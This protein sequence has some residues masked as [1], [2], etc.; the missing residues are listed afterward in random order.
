MAG[1]I[2]PIQLGLTDGDLVTLWAP[3]WREGDDEW[4]AFLGHGDD[5]YGFSSAAELA[6]FV[7]SDREHDLVEHPS[8]AIVA[9]LSAAEFEPDDTHVFDLVGV[10]E[11]VAG[12]PDADALGELE[13]TFEI[14]RSIGEVCDLDVVIRYFGANPVLD[15]V[16]AGEPAFVGRDGEQRWDQIGTAVASGWEAVIDAID[17]VV[18]T[19]QVDAAAVAEAEAEIVAAQENVVDADDAAEEGDDEDDDI[20]YV[21]LDGETDEEEGDDEETFWTSV[22]IDPVKIIT[23]ADTYFTLRCYL[24]D[25]P[26]FLGRAGKILAFTSE[27]AL[28]RFLADDHDHALARVSTYAEVQAAA[29]DGSLDVE[30]TDENV[31]VLPGLADDLADGPQSVDADQLDLA[32]E[33]FTDAAQFAGDESTEQALAPSTPLGWYVS[34]TLNPDPTRL[35]PSA[36]FTAEAQSWRD[37]EREFEARLQLV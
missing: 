8:W 14:V 37:L 16:S 1:D 19:P 28:A 15:A 31:Y 33:L 10:P 29:V 9:A 24:D 11:L 23:S 5:L 2:V 35:A 20:E 7:R 30:V 26:V 25:D 13:D 21:S 4:E 36:P 3:R 22:G 12:D 32:V 6:A 27:R 18:A 17:A 34:Y